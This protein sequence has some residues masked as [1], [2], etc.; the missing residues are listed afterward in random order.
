MLSEEVYRKSR[1]RSVTAFEHVD[2]PRERR[3]W[4]DED[5]AVGEQ[6]VNS[7]DVIRK[8][9]PKYKACETIATRYT[10]LPTR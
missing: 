3:T 1:S 9:M 8:L 7:A 2:A 5:G 4:C 10:R 6:I